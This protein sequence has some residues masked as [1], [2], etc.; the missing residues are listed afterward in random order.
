MEILIVIL[1]V[2]LQFAYQLYT[3]AKRRSKRLRQG[4]IGQGASKKQENRAGSYQGDPTR[5][6]N[7]TSDE[8]GAFF[9]LVGTKQS[10]HLSRRPE[11]KS[12]GIDYGQAQKTKAPD[13]SEDSE[14]PPTNQ[15]K[16]G[17]M[18]DAF[19]RGGQQISKTFEDRF[20]TPIERAYDVMYD[21]DGVVVKELSNEEPEGKKVRSWYHSEE[22]EE[23]KAAD[24][25]KKAQQ[26]LLEKKSKASVFGKIN[27]YESDLD[28][29]SNRVGAVKKMLK[30][31]DRK[32]AIV[33]TEI[34]SKPIALAENRRW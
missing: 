24:I 26:R 17:G 22:S 33:L 18:F 20:V 5:Y 11:R 3:A 28:Q 15:F 6:G 21:R 13:D 30:S 32:K 25:L 34:I 10:G 2:V 31:G 4:T 23:K 12:G 27:R 19:L 9:D 29:V 7:D 8:G 1:L 16:S 14:K